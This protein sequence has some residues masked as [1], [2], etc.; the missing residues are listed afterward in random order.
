MLGVVLISVRV[1]N[2]HC[3]AEVNTYLTLFS[4]VNFFMSLHREKNPMNWTRNGCELGS[5][6]C[7]ISS[8]VA[9]S[10]SV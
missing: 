2:P 3:I 9:D 4:L 6:F 5:S 10:V 8:E 1:R 7:V